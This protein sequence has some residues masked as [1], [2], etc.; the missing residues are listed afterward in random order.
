MPRVPTRQFGDVGMESAPDG[1]RYVM[2]ID[3]ETVVVLYND[4][5]EE[6][7]FQPG[8]VTYAITATKWGIKSDID[9]AE[10]LGLHEKDPRNPPELLK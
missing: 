7:D 3:G 1:K 5:P 10:R 9:L 8:L 6:A 4:V 2:Q